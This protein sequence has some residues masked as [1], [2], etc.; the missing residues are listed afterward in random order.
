MRNHFVVGVIPTEWELSTTVNYKAKGD[1]LERGNYELLKLTDQILE[2]VQSVIEKLI[3]QRVD[4][5]YIQFGFMA[6]NRITNSK[7]RD[8]YNGNIK[9]KIGICTLR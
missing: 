6:E 4:N 2:K 7:C 5:D 1:A 9:Q 8:S 3:W